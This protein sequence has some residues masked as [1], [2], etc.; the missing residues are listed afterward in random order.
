M[1]QRPLVLGILIAASAAIS[2]P[3]L[4]REIA[5][6]DMQRVLEE[7]KLGKQ[8]QANLQEQFGDEQQAFAE[9]E[10][11][12]RQLQ[13]TL[14]RDKPLMSA[15]Q[16][17]KTEEEI[18]GRIQKFEQDFQAIQRQ[19][20]QAQQQEGQKII[21]P[22]R[23]AVISVANKQKLG[24]VF[25]ASQAGIIYLDENGDITDAVIKALDAKTD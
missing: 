9:E 3:T 8:A 14:E 15:A 23:E 12:I 24:V 1:K 4:A 16:I 17:E 18:K 6:V 13:Q 25:E 2:A 21:Q 10:A 19:L 22:A 11:A 5:Y 7:S 20:A